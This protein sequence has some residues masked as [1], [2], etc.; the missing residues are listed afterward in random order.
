MEVSVIWLRI[1]VGVIHGES[2]PRLERMERHDQIR[3]SVL[4]LVAGFGIRIADWHGVEILDLNL[5]VIGTVSYDGRVFDPAD[6]EAALS[7]LKAALEEPE[8]ALGIGA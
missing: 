7:S 3:W 2:R 1:P 8:E 5:R 4:R 6:H